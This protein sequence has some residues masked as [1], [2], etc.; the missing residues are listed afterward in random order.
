LSTNKTAGQR[1]I[2][3]LGGSF[4]P[5]HHAHLSLARAAIKHADL[6][7]VQFI[8]AG[9]PWQRAKLKASPK[10]RAAMVGLAIANEPGFRLN[11]IEIER[12][13]P[14]Y[15]IETLRA[16]PIGPD[17]YWLLGAD[18]LENFCTWSDWASIAGM[19]TLLV[20]LRP[21]YDLSM[22]PAL[23]S[24]IKSGAARVQS[25]PFKPMATSATRVR[26]H[27]AQGQSVADDLSPAVIR[28]IQTHHLYQ[29]STRK[30]THG[31]Q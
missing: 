22:P 26:E 4:D 17:Y 31:Y 2:G 10:D 25:L 5:I 13:G 18:Q 15:T 9:Q 21:Q 6:N 16:L 28:Y 11:T 23:D 12:Q 20:A 19:V 24:L 27:L 7:E 8:P 1:R 3:L 30:Q 14:T 29:T